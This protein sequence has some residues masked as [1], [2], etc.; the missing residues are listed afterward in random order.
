MS[1]KVLR[2]VLRW[3]HL[4]IG[5]LMV[6]FVYSAALRE[7]AVFVGL[8]QFVVVPVVVVSGVAMWQQPLV[9]KLLR[10]LRGGVRTEEV[11]A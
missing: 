7:S 11:Q 5:G 8:M 3:S 9:G 1:N 6:A 4:V 10:G 2:Q